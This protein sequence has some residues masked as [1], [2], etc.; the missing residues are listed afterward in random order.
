MQTAVSRPPAS[1]LPAIASAAIAGQVMLLA[2]ALLLPI[3]SEY[4]L[5]SDN[6]SELVLGRLGS[7]QTIAF[8]I[9]GLTTLGLAFAIRELTRGIWGSVVGPALISFV[10]MIVGM[11][12]LYRTFLLEP[13]WR[14]L[15][16]W[17]VL[18]PAAALALVFCAIGRAAGGA[19]ATADGRGDRSL[20]DHGCAPGQNNRHDRTG[21]LRLTEHPGG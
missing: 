10:A 1:N 3:V 21:S 17:D 13:R 7:I 6:I 19:D 4:D 16:P 5:V 2:S 11:F 15:H 20:D 9:A 18:P 14:S 8:L 12:I